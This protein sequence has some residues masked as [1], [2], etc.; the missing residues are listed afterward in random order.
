MMN[1][2]EIQARVNAIIKENEQRG[3]RERNKLP[4]IVELARFTPRRKC[5]KRYIPIQYVSSGMLTFSGGDEYM[6][7]HADES[8]E[9]SPKVR[10]PKEAHSAA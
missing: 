9:V 7:I 1:L 10:K 3:W 2:Y 8:L 4:V 6:T 5:R